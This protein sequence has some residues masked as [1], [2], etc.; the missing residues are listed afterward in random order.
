MSFHL[1]S[2][3]NLAFGAMLFAVATDARESQPTVVRG[4]V[5][6]KSAAPIPNADVEIVCSRNKASI[7]RANT[8]SG[9][10]GHFQLSLVFMGV[11]KVKVVASG[12]AACY[13]QPSKAHKSGELNLGRISLDV[14]C[15]GPSVICDGV[16]PTK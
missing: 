4:V 14:S 1:S 15:S 7:R 5:I 12:F 11:C 2:V 13:I 3:R 8:K 6:D 10:D 9:P 16:T